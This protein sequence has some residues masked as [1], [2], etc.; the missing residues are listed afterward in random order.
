MVFAAQ[1][2]LR[3]NLSTPQNLKFI[4]AF[5]S[6]SRTPI[7]RVTRNE[8]TR[9]RRRRKPVSSFSE[10][11]LLPAA[12]QRTTRHVFREAAQPRIAIVSRAR[13]LSVP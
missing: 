11:V 8:P 6:P 13:G 5:P 1:E 12:R 7:P 4:G 3:D 10:D 9:C 2:L